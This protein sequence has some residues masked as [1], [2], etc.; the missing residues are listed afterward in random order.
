[1]TVKVYHSH[2]GLILKLRDQRLSLR[3]KSEF[4]P[5]WLARNALWISKSDSLKKTKKP[6]Y[7]QI[8]ASAVWFH[9]LQWNLLVHLLRNSSLLSQINKDLF[10]YFWRFRK[11][12]LQ[13]WRNTWKSG[14]VPM[15]RQEKFA[16]LFLVFPARLETW[17]KAFHSYSFFKC[18]R[19]E[20]FWYFLVN[21]IK[22]LPLKRW[23]VQ[24]FVFR[25]C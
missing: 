22:R 15:S 1:M 14:V 17:P 4:Y 6:G 9:V 25:L 21:F 3:A 20:V 23:P 7:F 5:R 24:N 13:K 19:N 8:I 2:H 11:P 16:D 12:K 10:E 18:S